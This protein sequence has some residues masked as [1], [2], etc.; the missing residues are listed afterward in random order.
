MKVQSNQPRNS[1]KLTVDLDDHHFVTK[2]RATILDKDRHQSDEEKLNSDEDMEQQSPIEKLLSY[3]SMTEE[4]KQRLANAN[5]TRTECPFA[6]RHETAEGKLEIK[7]NVDY[8]PIF[9][10]F[11]SLFDLFTSITAGQTAQRG[12]KRK[13]T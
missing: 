6:P 9:P 8:L 2:L 5:V 4:I 13:H 10:A 12:K 11:K 1:N 3:S 7:S